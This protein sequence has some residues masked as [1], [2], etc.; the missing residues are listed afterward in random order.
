MKNNKKF[1]YDS[2]RCEFVPVSHDRNKKLLHSFSFWFINSIVVAIVG[3]TILVNTVGS[4]AEI[5]LKAENQALLEQLKV[6]EKSIQSIEEQLESIA[7]LDNELYRSVLG[8]EPIPADERMAG[9]GGSDI[10]SDFDYYSLDT[11]ELLRNTASRLDVIERRIGIQKLS[12][13]EIKHS[14][15]ENRDKMTNLP[16]IKPVNGIILSGFGMR[17]HPVL[18]YRR[19][20]EGIDLRADVGTE[21]YV[22]GDGVVTHSGRKGA[23]GNLLEVDHGFGFVTRYAHLSGFANN[24]RP[25]TKVTRGQKVAYTG[26]TGLSSGP[27]LHYEVLKNNRPVDPLT[28]MVSDIS[29]EEYLMYKRMN[30]QESDLI[31]FSD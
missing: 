22:T 13:E 3:L 31:S 11:S 8:L 27:H 2:E 24:I 4:P 30:E 28:Y 9:I 26:N 20:H 14:Y 17:Q 1:Y 12:L 19:M 29:P 21:V 7:E 18:K 23:Y 10:Y 6:T 25:G 15:N 5:A 16:A